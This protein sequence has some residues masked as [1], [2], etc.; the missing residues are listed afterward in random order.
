MKR[1][2][3]A[4]ALVGLLSSTANAANR[5]DYYYGLLPPSAW[6]NQQERYQRLG[7][8]SF[9]QSILGTSGG[10][11]NLVVSPVSGLNVQVAPSNN[12]GASVGSVFQYLVDDAVS[13][14]TNNPINTSTQLPADAN[15]IIVQGTLI[16]AATA[17]IGPLT[18]PGSNSQ[19]SLI[20]CQVST[21]DTTALSSTFI[22]LGQYVPFSVNRDRT[23][24]IICQAKAGTA[25]PSPTVPSVDTGWIG[26]GYVTIPSGTSTITG[27]MITA[28]S[29]IGSAVIAD[30]NGNVSVT[31][32]VT[33]AGSVA[34]GSATGATLTAGDLGASRSTTTG[35]LK[36]GGSSSSCV[37][38][39]GVSAGST[40][41]VGCAE[42]ATSFSGT[43]TAL[44]ALN[45][46]NISSGT[47]AVNVGG[48]G[49][50][51]YTV[52]DLL[53][54][55]GATTLS[56]RADVATGSV[57]ASGGVGAAPIYTSAPTLSGANITG[58]PFSGVTGTVPCNQG[59]TGQTSY[60]VGDIP[61]ASASCTISKLA[62]VAS[63]SV[64]A[65]NGVG[66]APIYTSAPA[67]SGANI[68]AASIPDSA[69]A[70]DIPAQT[71][72]TWTPTDQSGA[73]LSLTLNNT[74]YYCKDGKQGT[75]WFDITYPTTASGAAA[76]I[77]LPF[78]CQSVNFGGIVA[79]N[80]TTTYSLGIVANGAT[81]QFRR[82]IATGGGGEANVTLT[83]G[84]LAGT[85]GC[86]TTS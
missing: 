24:T 57:L 73:S 3:A 56:K 54:A 63:G 80:S 46:S 22:N 9:M 41:T 29:A 42:V 21:I 28:L 48:T 6:Y 45:G 78:T 31:G 26:V 74:Q 70:A 18:V 67:I 64:L 30:Q 69:L 12:S 11:N 59:G 52:G 17:P 15:K 71:C 53:Y 51:S 7:D 25:A 84:H 86:Y 44:T 40:L 47:V 75:A 85:V 77:S 1:T 38:D 43:G 65:S 13:F 10:Y 81:F 5:I 61:Y 66:A 58:L 68:T 50:T 20:E 49:I 33:A 34:A 8:G 62:D 60:A 55:S 72:T 16:G 79:L 32:N 4:L 37:L 39:Y 14:P 36:L 23:D 35:A 19:I 83:G 76:A 82:L 2:L 27:G